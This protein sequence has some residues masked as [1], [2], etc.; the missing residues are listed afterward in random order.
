M[1]TRCQFLIA[2]AGAAASAA[3]FSAMATDRGPVQPGVDARQMPAQVDGNPVN[4]NEVVEPSRAHLAPTVAPRGTCTINPN[5]EPARDDTDYGALRS[6]LDA[7]NPTR[8]ADGFTTPADGATLDCLRWWGRYSNN[9]PTA[10]EAFSIAVYDDNGGLPNNQIFQGNFG[11]QACLCDISNDT[12][13]PGTPDGDVD[14]FDLLAYLTDWFPQNAAADLSDDTGTGTPDGDVDVFDLLYFLDCWFTASQDFS[15]CPAGDSSLSRA[16]T[17]GLIGTS[18]EYVYEVSLPSIAL[19]G[20]ACYHIEIARVGQPASDWQWATTDS[21][22][23]YNGYYYRNDSFTDPY[24]TFNFTEPPVDF[25]WVTNIDWT[26]Y[27]STTGCQRP[28]FAQACAQAYDNFTTCLD[29]PGG[30]LI[31]SDSDNSEGLG[32][33]LAVADDISD[34]V[35]GTMTEICWKGA[36]IGINSSGGLFIS[37]QPDSAGDNFTIRVYNNALDGDGFSLGHPTAS[38]I[39]TLRQGVDFTMTRGYDGNNF[40]YSAVLNAPISFPFQNE[41]YWISIENAAPNTVWAWYSSSGIGNAVYTQAVYSGIDPLFDVTTR[42]PGNDLTMCVDFAAEWIFACEGPL[43]TPEPPIEI[44]NG[45]DPAVDGFLSIAADGYGSWASGTFGGGVGGGAPGDQ[46]NPVGP[47]GASEAAFTSG[48]MIFADLNND[49]TNDS[50]EL[51]SDVADWQGVYTPDGTLSRGLTVANVASDTNSDGVN[52]TLTSEFVVAGTDFD[53]DFELT[54]SISGDV[55]TQTY[56]VTNT[57]TTAAIFSIVSTFD[58]DLLWDAAGNFAN[59]ELG[60]DSNAA[61]SGASVFQQEAGNPATRV[62]VSS[63]EANV[64]YGGRQGQTPPGGLP[65]WGYGTDVQLYDARGVPATWANTLPVLGTNVDGVTGAASND[66]FCGVSIDFNL[67]AGAS[68]TFTI[69]HD[70]GN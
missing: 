55:M 47:A 61:M 44:A 7:G 24:D 29:G 68:S 53:L 52:D 28:D 66:T 62:T 31:F 70:Y 30:T 33:Q 25:A 36:Y 2:L 15:A 35:G 13:T 26:Q 40:D 21:G 54:Q 60:T 67:A 12:A 11:S 5:A 27:N 34:F 17:G 41:C 48:L 4:P 22:F 58:G 59:D 9:A 1:T 37:R 20:N 57:G 43:V 19:A 16:V 64:Y 39:A 45:T 10:G 56:T 63:P 3:T 65:N 42:S 51:L 49:G 38:P 18:D 23:N 50:R 46:Y 8:R 14:V 32:A 6:E 69:V